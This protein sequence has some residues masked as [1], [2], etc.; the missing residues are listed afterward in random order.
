MA[1][2]TAA[3][4]APQKHLAFLLRILV[5]ALDDSL[6]RSRQIFAL[7]GLSDDELAERGLRR[8]DIARHVAHDDY[9]R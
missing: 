8:G 6:S 1:D 9:W 2:T 5:G 4:P 7:S 3:A